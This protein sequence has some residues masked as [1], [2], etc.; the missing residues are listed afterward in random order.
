[1]NPQITKGVWQMKIG[2]FGGAFDPIHN[3]HLHLAR[4]FAARLSLDKILLIPTFIPP[5]KV[6]SY[7]AP[8]QLRLQMCRLAVEGDSLFEVSD[9]EIRRGGASFTADT[10]KEISLQYPGAQLFLITG[11]DMFLTLGT[12]NR[13]EEIAKLAV[14]CAAPRDEY[15]S[16]KLLDYAKTLEQRGARCIIQDIPLLKI[17]STILRNKISDGEIL[18]GYVPEAVE[19]YIRK[20]G[21]YNNH[22]N[23]QTLNDEQ[24]IEIIRGRLTQKRFEHSLAVAEQAKHLAKLYGADPEK[25]YTAG[26]L[27]DIMKDA[28]KEAQLQIISDFGIILDNVEKNLP[29]CWHA[30]AGAVFIEHI[31]G[32]KDRDLINSVRYHT[33][34]RAGMSILEKVVYLADF[35]SADRDYPDVGTMRNLA[36]TDIKA[37]MKYG[38]SYTI[39]DLVGKSMPIHPDA[40]HAYNEIVSAI[41]KGGTDNGQKE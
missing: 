32:I 6:R 33:T 16:E 30:I 4:E 3:G 20:Y 23:Q 25:A 35:T 24:F 1:M 22:N 12:W 31:L 8:A 38:L 9:I 41:E 17:S 2:V 18:E 28:G 10:L 21:L 29:G 5:H 26:I 34:A 36:A 14:L 37:A 13:F 7:M 11:A 15:N 39:K 40:I 19:D 27:H